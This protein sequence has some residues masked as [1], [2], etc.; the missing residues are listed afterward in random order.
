MRISNQTK[1]LL[2]PGLRDSYDLARKIR[3]ILREDYKMGNS[4]ELLEPLERK[5]LPKGARKDHRS[6]LVVDFFPDMEVQADV[7]RNQLKD[8]IRG[9]HIALVQYMYNPTEEGSVND[10]LMTI[11]GL[12]D[13][14]N[15]TE[16][17]H[18]SLIT[19]YPTYLRAHSADQYRRQGFFQF[20][21]LSLIVKFLNETSLNTV[22]GIDPH[23]KKVKSVCDKY[24][25]T[26]RNIN[27][28]QSGRS[29]DPAKLGLLD[30]NDAKRVIA[31]LRPYQERF[32]RLKAEHPDHI[33][34]ISVDD[35]TEP[36]TS[37]F[38][39]R[40]FPELEDPYV[41]LAYLGK[42][43]DGY[44]LKHIFFKN[45]SRIK[46]DNIDPKGIYIIIDD[47]Y[48]SGGTADDVGKLFKKYGAKCV[49]AWTTHAVTSK[50][51]R[52]KATEREGLDRVVCMNTIKQ[53]PVLGFEYSEA[54]EDL[55]SAELFK[56]H[57][58]VLAMR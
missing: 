26:F 37:N 53:D 24:G 43:R 18:R 23:S 42:G 41:R 8:V 22:I 33:Y 12:L 58:S 56:E 40:G 55:L 15:N 27:P 3:E 1:L 17:V 45:F 35:G 6:P 44:E 52:K 38:V 51:Q 39:D 16:T 11:W 2:I 32:S 9:K 34:V 50:E 28:F 36:R 7:G 49:E 13:L 30:P 25:M 47:M 19:P 31:R 20:D 54:S 5:D 14:I 4:V 48:A 21:S 10:R 29:I 57:E 46:E